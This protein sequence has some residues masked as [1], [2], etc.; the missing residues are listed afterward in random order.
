MSIQWKEN[1]VVKKRKYKFVGKENSASLSSALVSS[2][3]AKLSIVKAIFVSFLFFSFLFFFFKFSRHKQNENL[4][5]LSSQK[6][7][8]TR[9]S[10]SSFRTMNYRCYHR[11]RKL[12]A[13]TF[14]SNPLD[15]RLL[16]LWPFRFAAPASC[17]MTSAPKVRLC[18]LS[19]Y[20]ITFRIG[21]V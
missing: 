12:F 19:I 4:N 17:S 14:L 15:N 16:D 8:L 5:F 2:S 11:Y 21:L 20:A 3:I 6:Q 10:T 7:L 13:V 18:M 9:S 1:L